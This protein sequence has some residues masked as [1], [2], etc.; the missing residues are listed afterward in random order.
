M[1]H[2]ILEMRRR[3]PDMMMICDPS[4]ICGC[5]TYLREISQTAADL[6]YDGLIIESHICPEQ[7]LSDAAQQHTP[8]DLEHMIRAYQG[9]RTA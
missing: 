3:F 9:A 1:W 7:A 2:M 8:D 6:R 4:H 5:R